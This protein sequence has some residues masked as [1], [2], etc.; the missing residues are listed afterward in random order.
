MK[1]ASEAISSDDIL[2]QKILNY[3]FNLFHSF[4]ITQVT[5]V[6]NF[7]DFSFLLFPPFC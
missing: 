7:I 2:F 1:F 4:K 6:F 5:S 3:I